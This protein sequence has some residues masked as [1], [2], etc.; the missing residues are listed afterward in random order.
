MLGYDHAEVDLV[1][2][3]IAVPTEEA[4]P[5]GR[6]APDRAG[7]TSSRDNDLDRHLGRVVETGHHARYHARLHAG[8]DA[9]V[10]AGFAVAGLALGDGV[11]HAD[12]DVVQPLGSRHASRAQTTLLDRGAALVEREPPIGGTGPTGGMGGAWIE[13]DDLVHEPTPER[14]PALPGSHHV[15][16]R[17]GA[18]LPLVEV[19]RDPGIELEGRDPGA[20]G[21]AL[22]LEI[23]WRLP[24]IADRDEDGYPA[25]L[26]WCLDVAED[27]LPSS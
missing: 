20:S 17:V 25:G 22:V 2:L 12:H 16:A 23:D 1:D 9:R 11:A 5:G 21:Q 10:L 13:P 6:T 14:T 26:R 24:I 18:E 3:A 27:G 7:R 15:W 4:G 19:H 8:E